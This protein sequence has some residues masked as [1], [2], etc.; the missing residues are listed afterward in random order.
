MAARPLMI[1][2]EGVKGPSDWPLS[3]LLNSGASD[4]AANSTK[5][6]VMSVGSCAH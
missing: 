5:V 6:T 2:A 1:S 4:P 3:A